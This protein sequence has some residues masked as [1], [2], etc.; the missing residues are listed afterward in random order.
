MH[1][2]TPC[3]PH[4]THQFER[5][6]IDRESYHDTTRDVVPRMPSFTKK[7]FRKTFLNELVGRQQPVRLPQGQPVNPGSQEKPIT[8]SQEVPVNLSQEVSVN[9]SQEVPV[10]LSQEVPVSPS[11][12]VPVSPSQGAPPQ[13]PPASPTQGPPVKSPEIPPPKLS[14]RLPQELADEIISYIHDI[15]TLLACSLT[16]R[17]WYNAA[18]PR[19]HYSLTTFTECTRSQW[20]K[21]LLESHELHLLPFVKRFGILVGPHYLGFTRKLFGDKH[22]LRCFS[23][24]KNLR[25]LRIDRLKLSSFMPNIKRYFGHFA[26]TLRS[27]VLDEPE[28]S[29]QQILYFIGLFPNLHHLKLL[30]FSPSEEVEPLDRLVPHSQPPLGGWLALRSYKGEKFVEDM[31]AHYGRLP[32]SSLYLSNVERTQRVLDECSETLETLQLDPWHDPYG[33]NSFG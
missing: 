21:P 25:E 1:S 17:L 7:L 3:I 22:N 26:P 29:C 10:S 14:A 6:T 9:L 16:S 5:I 12:E 15:E 4:C 31:V 19:L 28:A 27:L 13:G 30:L 32:F 20:P 33:E 8:P 23:T 24:L 2:S 18:V 11:Q